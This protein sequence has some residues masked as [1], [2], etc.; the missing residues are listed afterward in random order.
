MREAEAARTV[1]AA[2]VEAEMRDPLP[3]VLSLSAALTFFL[4][5]SP[6]TAQTPVRAP[7]GMVLVEGGTFLQGSPD[8]EDGRSFDEGPRREVAVSS[9]FL[10][11]R[12]LTFDE[13]DEFSSAVGRPRLPDE[14]WGRWTRPVI[15]VTWRDAV[16]YSN[17]RSRKEG[18]T[19]AYTLDGNRVTWNLDADGYRLPTE[20]EWEFAARGGRRSGG[21]R[22]SGGNDLS[23]VAWHSLNSNIRTQPV[24][25]RAPNELGLHDMSGNVWEWCWD[26]YAGY[27]AG[28]QTDP[29]GPEEAALRVVRGGAYSSMAPDLRPARRWFADPA[30]R[31]DR[32]GFRLARSIP[33]R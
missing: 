17:W 25:G 18:L 33:A 16:E 30:H 6:L 1:D 2:S 24:G 15:N 13:Y 14:G 31:F 32:V 11:R 12:E 26:W 28:R 4:A 7:E 5:P 3:L 29:R 27:T 21:F 9:F 23:V 19:P 10:A 22:F 8:I 20:A